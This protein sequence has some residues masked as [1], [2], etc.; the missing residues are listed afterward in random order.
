[1]CNS[2]S[3]LPGHH[4]PTGIVSLQDARS[5]LCD[6]P[7]GAGA[8]QSLPATQSHRQGLGVG[9]KERNVSGEGGQATTA[10]N[11]EGSELWRPLHPNSAITA[12]AASA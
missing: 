5:L 4:L 11:G 8:E 9:P 7:R 1:M 2:P 12:L 10:P 6:V 3:V